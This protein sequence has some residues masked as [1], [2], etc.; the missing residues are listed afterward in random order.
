MNCSDSQKGFTLIEAVLTLIIISIIGSMMYSYF[1]SAL[2]Y[3][4][5]SLLQIQK[6]LELHS[7][8]EK[9]TADYYDKKGIPGSLETLQIN[10]QNNA[11]EKYGIYEIT[12][13][14]F[15]KFETGNEVELLPTDPDPKN[16]LK[17]TINNSIG[18]TLTSL[19]TDP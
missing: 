10:V 12:K 3:G 1:N 17:I 13:N 2:N 9:I 5:F 14:V 8:M 6:S 15:I 11:D 16:I 4:T 19:F 18:E 7:A